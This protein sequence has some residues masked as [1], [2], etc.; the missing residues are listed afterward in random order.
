MQPIEESIG[1]VFRDPGYPIPSWQS[2]VSRRS[3]FNNII[4]SPPWHL[5]IIDIMEIMMCHNAFKLTIQFL[6]FFHHFVPL[7]QFVAAYLCNFFIC[8]EIAILFID[9]ILWTL[10]WSKLFGQCKVHNMLS[11]NKIAISVEVVF[12]LGSMW[13][14]LCNNNLL[15][16]IKTCWNFEQQKGLKN[17]K[18]Y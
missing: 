10:H 6:S 18:N 13:L 7:Y 8:T 15:L 5:Y 3:N 9:N 12:Y 4:F 1:K 2:K 17:S 16:H 11:I 14:T